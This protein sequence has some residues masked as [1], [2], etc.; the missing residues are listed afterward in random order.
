MTDDHDAKPKANGTYTVIHGPPSFELKEG[1]VPTVRIPRARTTPNLFVVDEK[2]WHYRGASMSEEHLKWTFVSE[3]PCRVF[4]ARGNDWHPACNLTVVGKYAEGLEQY[5]KSIPPVLDE[6][7][8]D[9]FRIPC[10][11]EYNAEEELEQPVNGTYHDIEF[12]IQYHGG[13]ELSLSMARSYDPLTCNA[14]P[15]PERK[16]PKPTKRIPGT[17]LFVPRRCPFEFPDHRN[18]ERFQSDVYRVPKVPNRDRGPADN[19]RNAYRDYK[20]GSEDERFDLKFAAAVQADKQAGKRKWLTKA[21]SEDWKVVP[22]SRHIR[23]INIQPFECEGEFEMKVAA[24][25]EVADPGYDIKYRRGR[26]VLVARCN[27]RNDPGEYGS[28]HSR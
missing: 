27:L 14:R 5:G 9:G 18:P 6:P 12:L 4:F 8:A 26:E 22:K 28:C 24:E 16:V 17:H 15:E 21:M 7:N 10:T 2:E 1:P 19:T 13:A 20:E 23:Q 11:F 3:V 25:E